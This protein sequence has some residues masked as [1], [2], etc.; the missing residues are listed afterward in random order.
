MRCRIPLSG[1]PAV[2][3]KELLKTALIHGV[4]SASVND[5]RDELSRPNILRRVKGGVVYAT[6]R[7]VLREEIA[8]RDFVREGRGKH[9]KL[10]GIKPPSLDEQLSKEQQAAALVILG[11]RDTVTALKGG[12]GT[13][14]TRMMQA[15]VK[16]IE[17]TGKQVFTF[18][19]SA[20]A[21]RGVLRRKASKM[22]I[23]LS[24]CSS[25]PKCRKPSMARCSGWMRPGC[26][27]SRI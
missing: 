8:M 2:P 26:S 10:G 14:K 12:A 27:R 5:I 21:S 6:T 23:Q 25:I 19:P 7:E 3:E 18:A 16:A 4:G 11:S 13:G 20:E 15:T 1:H 9:I 24:G 22:P 17:S